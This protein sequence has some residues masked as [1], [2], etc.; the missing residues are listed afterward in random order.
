MRTFI[1]AG[2]SVPRP[3]RERYVKTAAFLPP[4][5]A[6]DLLRL[7]VRPGDSVGIIDGYFARRPPVRHKE[8]LNL[9]QDGVAVH[10]AASMGALR[11]AEL[12]DF[13]MVGHGRIF[14]DY[15]Q[16]RVIGDDEVAVL[17]GTQAD[18]FAPCTEAMINIRYAVE[19]ALADGVIEHQVAK[20][21]LAVIGRLPFTER[22]R[23]NIAAACRAAGLSAAEV[24]RLGQLMLAAPDA[25]KMDA[26]ILLQAVSNATGTGTGRQ[27]RLNET[28]YLRLWRRHAQGD[29]ITGTGFVSGDQVHSLCQVMAIDYPLF[30]VK[31]GQRA[32]AAQHARNLGLLSGPGQPPG[33][34][35]GTGIPGDGVLTGALRDHATR[36]GGPAGS[37][38]CA[39]WRWACAERLRDLGL[40]APGEASNAALDRWCT[41]GELS[42]P[43]EER[44]SRAATRALLTRNALLWDDPFLGALRASGAYQRARRHVAASITHWQSLLATKPT[45]RMEQ[46]REDKISEHF[47]RRWGSSDF[48]EAILERGFA[49]LE[50]FF[51]CARQYYLYAKANPGIRLQLLDDA[52]RA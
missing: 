13:G 5:Q 22:T 46:L 32:I 50:E 15:R 18:G 47:A 38:Q 31:V 49:S 23:E 48:D 52:D 29:D 30:R 40:L 41:A 12:A 27:W 44:A 45:L 8:I 35:H 25:K 20:A 1:F 6:G 36:S 11:A 2:P 42:L 14:E 9:I 37:D 39:L 21:A 26:A 7:P 24:A 17:H 33:S 4:V 43:P 51:A 28:I 34:A 3:L 10:G 19:A 16:T